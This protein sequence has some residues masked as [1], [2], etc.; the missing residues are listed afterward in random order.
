MH[1]KT[2]WFAV[3]GFVRLS[4]STPPLFGNG[5]W[6]IL[7]EDDVERLPICVID[8]ADDHDEP[9][10]ESAEKIAR[11]IA[12]APELLE[13]CKKAI[14]FFDYEI[15]INA[16]EELNRILMELKT[17]ISKAEANP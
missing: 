3:R 2:K 15:P 12:A 16:G 13:A 11:L 14:H 4:L 9:T 10:R 5:L 7:P 6:N 1:T 17:A 8:Y